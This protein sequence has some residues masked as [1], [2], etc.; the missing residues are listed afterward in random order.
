MEQAAKQTPVTS[1]DNAKDVPK[2]GETNSPLIFIG[3]TLLIA[4]AL[5]MLIAVKLSRAPR[6]KV[7]PA[8]HVSGQITKEDN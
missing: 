4:G 3:I 1:Y 8:P 2:T 5:G 7:M 6:R